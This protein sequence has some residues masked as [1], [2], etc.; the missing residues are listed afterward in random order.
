M[1]QR[2]AISE[3]RHAKGERSSERAGTKVS[4]R[5]PSDTKSRLLE[6]DVSGRLFGHQ[7]SED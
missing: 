2:M 7:E 6:L 5:L 1:I 4:L 3:K